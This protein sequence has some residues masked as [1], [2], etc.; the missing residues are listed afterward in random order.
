[1]FLGSGIIT[2]LK[3][4]AL[5][6][7]NIHTVLLLILGA[8]WS[9]AFLFIKIGVETIP[10][11][12]V[13]AGRIVLA[14]ILLCIY[15]KIRGESLPPWGRVWWV[16]FLVGL[17][18]N[19]LPFTLIGWGEQRI[20]SSL[21]AILMAI[22]PLS[23]VLLS[24]FLT[25]D[26]RLNGPRI[27]GVVFGLAGVVV[28]VGPETLLRLG[29]DAWRQLAV[30]GGA[31]C[32]AAAAVAARRLPPLPPASRGAAVMLCA[33]LQMLPLAL[34]FDQPWTLAPSMESTVAVIYLGLFPTALATI[35]LFYLLTLR[36]ATYVAM[37]NYLIPVFGVFLGALFLGEQITAQAMGALALILIGIAIASFRMKPLAP[38]V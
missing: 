30:A 20:D 34:W 35:M 22:M 14:A 9:S 28:L 1:M 33:T 4:P 24:H 11:M 26:E 27:A 17:L 15:L 18:G 23:T 31:L 29:E 37:N 12:T 2:T 5:T 21:A 8:I 3:H 25:S 32:Y 36:G 16:V 6:Y 10:P 13:A 19:G 38:P 7:P